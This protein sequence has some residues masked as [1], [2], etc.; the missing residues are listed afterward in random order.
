MEVSRTITT[1][2][3]SAELYCVCKD[4]KYNKSEMENMIGILYD[5]YKI[6]INNRDIGLLSKEYNDEN[7]NIGIKKMNKLFFYRRFTCYNFIILRLNNSKFTT[8]NDILNKKIENIIV[9]YTNYYFSTYN[10]T[11]L[12][13]NNKL[14]SKKYEGW[15]QQRLQINL[16]SEEYKK[17]IYPTEP[18]LN[19]EILM[20]YLLGESL[21]TDF[22]YITCDI[23]P[24]NIIVETF[25]NIN[26]KVALVNE[27]SLKIITNSTIK[28]M[29]IYG[30]CDSIKC[31]S[32]VIKIIK[33][34]NEFITNIYIHNTI[35]RSEKNRGD[36]MNEDIIKNLE[37]KY[38]IKIYY[39]GSQKYPQMNEVQFKDN[40]LYIYCY[41]ENLY[42]LHNNEQIANI[43]LKVLCR[44]I[45]GMDGG[46]CIALLMSYTNI[47]LFDIINLV[48]KYFD[49]TIIFSP[50]YLFGSV[51]YVIFIGKKTVMTK[52]EY[53]QIIEIFSRN[54]IYRLYN[55]D[56]IKKYM[57]FLNKVMEQYQNRYLSLIN[58][59]YMK[60]LDN[61]NEYDIIMDKVD[62]Y[63]RISCIP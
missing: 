56:I 48:S 54:N 53:D 55:C 42:Y 49:K 41:V 6:Y 18:I 45:F 62:V 13:D 12:E 30:E 7:F 50:K 15:K 25:D 51:L 57:E 5:W 38:D 34:H 17:F 23:N 40:S 63:K 27:K 61:N 35:P 19:N 11:K 60:L 39:Y 37:T 28:K 31:Y 22:V 46:S 3:T 52:Q 26:S 59:A 43:Y 29:N 58:V 33:K 14:V 16:N 9:H 21:Y 1:K 32:K 2:P 4:F 24:S 20:Y 10:I 36:S 44:T 47:I 8:G